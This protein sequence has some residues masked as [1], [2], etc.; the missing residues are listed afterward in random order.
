MRTSAPTNPNAIISLCAPGKHVTAKHMAAGIQVAAVRSMVW[1][2]GYD[3]TLIGP[4][5][6]RASG[7]M[8]LK[9][10]GVSDSMIQKLGRWRSL[11]WL[12]YLHGQISCLAR[13]VAAAMATPVLHQ[14]IGTRAED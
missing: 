10:T 4:H 11:T 8:Q 9:L 12:T 6:L 5:S 2:H 1:L 13:A 3:I 7:A 14:N